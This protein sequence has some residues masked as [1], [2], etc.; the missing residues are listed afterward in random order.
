LRDI[1]GQKEKVA[2][3]CKRYEKPVG[4]E[5]A[6]RLQGTVSMERFSK[7]VLVT[8]SR[9]TRGCKNEAQRDNRLELIDGNILVTLL[10]QYL[11][12]EWIVHIDRLISE[13]QRSNVLAEAN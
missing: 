10:N 2:I 12:S 11:G 3:E 8:S 4:V 5:F 6:R 13:S 9:F 7:G 1:I